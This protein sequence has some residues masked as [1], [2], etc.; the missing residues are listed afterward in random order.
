M[1]LQTVFFLLAVIAA[2]CVACGQQPETPPAPAEKAPE[3]AATPDET[4]AALERQCA[5]AAPEMAARQAERSLFERVGGREGLHVVV[6]D[7]V[8]R[9]ARN[10]QIKHLLDGV[11]SDNLIEL[12]TDFLV[13]GTGGEGEYTGRDMQSAHAHLALDNADFLAAGSDLDAAMQAAGWADA[14]RQELLCAFVSLRGEV[15]TR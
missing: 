11:D 4:V 15:V 13:L 8:A 14:E 6:A 3:P 1:R 10:E 9:H 7:T 5:Q 12:V 2:G